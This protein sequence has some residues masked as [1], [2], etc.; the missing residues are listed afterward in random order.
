MWH[1]IRMPPDDGQVHK[2]MWSIR[3]WF[4]AG[5][6][7]VLAGALP[8]PHAV[9]ERAAD[10][11]SPDFDSVID[12]AIDAHGGDALR[13]LQAIVTE[14]TWSDQQIFE[15]RRPGP[16]WDQVRRWAGFA[17]AFDSRQYAEAR[18]DRTGGYE[19]I[20]GLLIDGPESRRLDYRTSTYTTSNQ[21]SGDALAEAASLSPLVLLRWLDGNRGH[22]R[23]LGNRGTG[24]DQVHVLAVTMGSEVV[25]VS[26]NAASGRIASVRRE[27]SDY[28]GTQVPLRIRYSDARSSEALVYPARAEVHVHGQ[29][30]R[31][32]ELSHIQFGG[33]I[34]RYLEL[35]TGFK[36]V[37][38]EPGE[39]REYR[40]AEVAEGVFFVGEGVMYQL[41]VE[42]DDFVV[43]LDGSSGDV[44]RRIATARE[45]FPD[46]PFRYVLASHHH[47]DHLHG[48]DDFAGMGATI[49]VSPAHRATVKRYVEERLGSSPDLLEVGDERTIRSG[50]R[51]L[52]VIDIGPTPH[53]EHILA[54]YLPAEKIL[55]SADLFVLGGR[56]EPVR[57]A[58]ENG[59]A[60]FDAIKARDLDVDIIVDPHSPLI[61]SMSDLRQ[62]VILGRDRRAD[63]LG[64]A[65]SSL[66]VWQSVGQVFAD[67]QGLDSGQQREE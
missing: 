62:A 12:L 27:Y 60:L 19:W 36:R 3:A 20:T 55:Y 49:L 4:P 59:F 44:A 37:P 45:L 10:A 18:V 33:G 25:E 63:M 52:R 57:P 50:D 30:G 9:A 32:A 43:A 66:G 24:Q 26:I 58:M 31:R 47:N 16:P 22:A 51:E 35:P 54:A 21:Q 42:F 7:I 17:V 11:A 34:D 67:V 14:W 46:K 61:A 28:D 65:W 64:T 5:V 39:V 40:V 48:L 13:S 23:Y 8:A 15:S 41:F 2:L 29:V 38:V 6:A 56:R 1:I 53:S